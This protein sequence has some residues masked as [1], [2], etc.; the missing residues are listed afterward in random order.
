MH[1]AVCYSADTTSHLRQNGLPEEIEPQGGS[2]PED[3]SIEPS[4]HVAEQGGE[5][6]LVGSERFSPQD[7]H[8]DEKGE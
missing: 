6:V 1:S 2:A 5:G 7:M 3:F 8:K 4:N